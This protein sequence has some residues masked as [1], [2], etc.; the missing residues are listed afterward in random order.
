MFEGQDRP[1]APKGSLRRGDGGFAV[2]D[3]PGAAGHEPEAGRGFA[4]ICHQSLRNM[5][6][7]GK[8]RE[9]L[10]RRRTSFVG[11]RHIKTPQM[12]HMADK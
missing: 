6:R 2:R 3:W 10:G 1:E 7:P 8:R 4:G 12:D 5:K 9:L 11:W